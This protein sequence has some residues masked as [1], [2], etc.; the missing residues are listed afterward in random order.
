MVDRGRSAA[1]LG[2]WQVLVGTS[3]DAAG[4]GEALLARWSEPHRSYHA[5]SHL[6]AVLRRL[7]RLAAA[8]T[9]VDDAV[10]LAAWW[11]D[12]VYDVRRADNEARSAELASGV[13]VSLG[14]PETTATRGGPPGGADGRAPGRGGRPGRRRP[15]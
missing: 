5:L 6:A 9:T 8:G 14:W 13:M 2:R 12:A 10:E 1:L 15:V 11:H 7:D 4:A 3:P